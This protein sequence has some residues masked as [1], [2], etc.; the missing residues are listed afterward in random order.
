MPWALDLWVGGVFWLYQ[1]EQTNNLITDVLVV[2]SYQ[3][4]GAS[5]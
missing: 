1:L 4:D 5:L 3:E 2:K